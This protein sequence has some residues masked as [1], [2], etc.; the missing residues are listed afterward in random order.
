MRKYL[1][2]IAKAR[3]K[4]MGIDRINRHMADFWRQT[5]TGEDGEEAERVQMNYGQLLK[6]QREGRKAK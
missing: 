4:C 1:R 2:S 3:M 5:L 6:A